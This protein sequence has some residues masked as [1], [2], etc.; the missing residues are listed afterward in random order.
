MLNVVLIRAAAT[1]VARAAISAGVGVIVVSALSKAGTAV[2]KEYKM[3][4]AYRE[5]YKQAERE[6]DTEYG[7]Y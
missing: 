1:Y 6:H 5:A 7:D 4:R 2:H 3:Y